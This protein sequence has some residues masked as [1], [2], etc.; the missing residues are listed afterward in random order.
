VACKP[1]HLAI[2]LGTPGISLAAHG[3]AIVAR[4]LTRLW[5]GTCCP[6]I[7][8]GYGTATGPSR[9]G[10]K[11]SG[12]SRKADRRKRIEVVFACR[13]HALR[14]RRVPLFLHDDAPKRRLCLMRRRVEAALALNLKV[15]GAVGVHARPV[16][17]KGFFF[18]FLEDL[19]DAFVRFGG[20]QRVNWSVPLGG[21]NSG[22]PVDQR[23]GLSVDNASAK[24]GVFALLIIYGL[25]KEVEKGRV[26]GAAP[27]EKKGQHTPE[28][29]ASKRHG[30]AGYEAKKRVPMKLQS[31]ART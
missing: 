30:Q 7:R 22:R 9:G 13:K 27:G 24:D 21:P 23:P 5:L 26:R 3:E 15:P 6:W 31:G 17:D 19:V 25:V 28:K 20:A 16:E 10:S 11:E 29:Q 18:L 12:A 14:E 1:A 8:G 2:A 4:A